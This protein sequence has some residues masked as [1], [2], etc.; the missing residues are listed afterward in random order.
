MTNLEGGILLWLFVV[1]LLSAMYGRELLFKVGVVMWSRRKVNVIKLFFFN[2]ISI[3]D[4]LQAFMDLL[5]KCTRYETYSAF[6][7]ESVCWGFF[8][9]LSF[10][11]ASVFN[12]RTSLSDLIFFIYAI[13]R[14]P[15]SAISGRH[16][17]T[18]FGIICFIEVL[19]YI[20][21]LIGRVVSDI[22]LDVFN[23]LDKIELVFL[24]KIVQVKFN[25]FF[26]WN[27]L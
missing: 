27:H 23:L 4:N 7:I 2:L 26:L 12:F 14:V 11:H 17:L 8:R 9:L 3:L 19:E 20:S 10:R 18:V 25:F 5:A 15:S 6:R 13:I 22:L 21:F 24:S 1:Y 16:L